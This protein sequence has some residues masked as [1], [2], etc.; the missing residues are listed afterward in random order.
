MMHSPL[1]DDQAQLRALASYCNEE[2]DTKLALLMQSL[3]HIVGP[4][5][6]NRKKIS[7]EGSQ[8]ACTK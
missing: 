3:R 2:R 7:E 6:V 5:E 4:L 1:Y 8:L